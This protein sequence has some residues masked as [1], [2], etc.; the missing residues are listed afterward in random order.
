MCAQYQQLYLRYMQ[1]GSK[2]LS[3]ATTSQKAI[4]AAIRKAPCPQNH[5]A[6]GR[7]GASL[8]VLAKSRAS[9][10]MA[11]NYLMIAI[12]L[13]F[14]RSMV[15]HHFPTKTSSDSFENSRSASIC[16]TPPLSSA[17]ISIRSPVLLNRICQCS[18]EQGNPIQYGRERKSPRQYFRGAFVEVGEV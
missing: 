1:K 5:M 11:K 7:S 10:L 16:T 2:K 6:M 12:S 13:L 14:Q 15:K 9:L 4:I 3:S 17:S 8:P 18:I